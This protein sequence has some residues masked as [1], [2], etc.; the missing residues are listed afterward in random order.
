MTTVKKITFLGT[1]TSHGIPVIG[2]DC[3][4]C[5]S[6]DPK[7]NRNRTSLL[8]EIQTNHNKYPKTKNIIIDTST[9][10]RQ[11]CLQ[12]NVRQLDAILFTHCHADHVFGLDD[13]RIFNKYQNSTIPCYAEKAVVEELKQV[14]KYIFEGAP[15]EGGGLPSLELNTISTDFQVQGLTIQPIRLMHGVVPITGYRFADIAYLTDCNS[16]PEESIAKLQGLDVLILDALR[17]R[18]HSTHFNLEQAVEVAKQIKAKQ[19]YFTHIAH[20]LPHAETNK[21]LPDGM[22]LAH[23]GL[24]ILSKK[25]EQSDYL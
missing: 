10:L 4:V 5:R 16:I 2:C 7:D 17:I 6:K 20:E 23:D 1:G 21:Q 22:Q 8:I 25:L 14:F 12:N 9:D 24:S 18:P 11:Q 15:Q 13:V 19:T 3:P